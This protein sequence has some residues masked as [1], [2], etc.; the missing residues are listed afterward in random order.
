MQVWAIGDLHLAIGTPHKSMEVFGENWKNYQEKIRKN[1]EK[2]VLPGDLVLIPGDIC[3]ATN[4]KQAMPDLNWIDSLPGKKILIKGNH[5]YWWSSLKKL[6]ENLPPS[7][8]VLQNDAI[9]FSSITI[10]GARLW[11]TK[12]Y[13]FEDIIDYTV[14]P[15]STSPKVQQEESEKIFARELHRLELSLSK[16]SPTATTKIVMTHYPPISYDLKESNASELLEK[17]NVNICIFGHLH[18][19]KKE[20]P[21]FGEKNNVK[22]IFTSC[23]YLD[24][25][26]IK[27][28]G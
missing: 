26:P 22:Y 28:V 4:L 18:N 3:W 7:I 8:Y 17:Y 16:M 21:I 15:V 24:F 12:E 2:N 19:V 11:D 6:K 23:D 5:D 9:T 13:N 14:S 25:C 20:I 1:W 27:I 10:A